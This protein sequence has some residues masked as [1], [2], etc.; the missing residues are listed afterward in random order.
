LP[1]ER[2][3]PFRRHETARSVQAPFGIWRCLSPSISF[4]S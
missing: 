3:R 4:A 1:V 2:S